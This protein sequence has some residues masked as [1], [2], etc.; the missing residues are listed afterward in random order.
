MSKTKTKKMLSVSMLVLA[1]FLTTLC[2]A[3]TTH[4]V[5]Y[6]TT[7][8]LGE[9]FTINLVFDYPLETSCLYGIYVWFY[10]MVNNEYTSST[11]GDGMRKYIY[12]LDNY[13]RITNVSWTFDTTTMYYGALETDDIYQF[14]I[15]YDDGYDTGELV[16]FE[17]LVVTDTYEI[18]IG[19]ATTE[20]TSFVGIITSVVILS[21]FV[22]TVKKRRVELK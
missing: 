4:T 5:E 11:W 8:K 19:D 9:K 17:G 12:N 6:P 15:R 21:A 13:P 10:W 16:L 22:L 18:T 7:V 1:L 3:S 14:R 20:K 2:N